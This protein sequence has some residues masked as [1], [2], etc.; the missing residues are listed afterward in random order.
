V[1]IN[2]LF[3]PLMHPHGGVIK[4]INLE[5]EE[6][7]ARRL[8]NQQVLTKD[9]LGIL[10]SNSGRNITPVEMAL[11]IKKQGL[12]LIAITNL[13]QSKISPSLHPCGKR[14]FEI[15]DIVLDNR[16]PFGDA[17]IELEPLGQKIGPTSTLIG[18]LI[19]HGV[20]VEAVGEMLK[21]G[22][23]PQI[24]KSINIP[25]GG[26]DELKTA[27]KKFSNRIRFYEI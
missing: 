26:V 10:I 3:D 12:P 15:A 2:L 24:L 9:D 19:L 25:E 22:V 20:L 21:K 23:Y 17:G 7:F 11:E 6:G 1:A 27:L 13:R 14:V 4:A 16:C 5:R 8:L 18:I